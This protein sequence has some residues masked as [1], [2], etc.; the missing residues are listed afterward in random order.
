MPRLGGP[1]GAPITDTDIETVLLTAAPSIEIVKSGV[2]NDTNTDGNADAGETITYTYEV[3]NTGNQTLTALDV[4]DSFTLPALS[5][6]LGP[7]ATRS[8]RGRTASERRRR[9]LGK[10]GLA[11]EDEIEVRASERV[12]NPGIS[13]HSSYGG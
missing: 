8:F 10:M 6:N 1:D 4:S 12:A 7:T 2:F 11:N 5:A 9:N 3:E 13:I